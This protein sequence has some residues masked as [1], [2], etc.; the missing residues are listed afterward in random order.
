M[1]V[2]FVAVFGAFGLLAAPTADLVARHEVRIFRDADTTD[3]IVDNA[4][5]VQAAAS[6]WLD[7]VGPAT[8]AAAVA[9]LLLAAT[10]VQVLRRQR[11]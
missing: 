11:R 4:A 5:R 6:A 9:V 1:T 8:V 2:G 3:P 10:A 7:R